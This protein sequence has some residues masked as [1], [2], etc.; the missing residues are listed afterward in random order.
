ML[1][2]TVLFTV[3]AS[4][5][6]AIA[7]LPWLFWQE[8]FFGSERAF[9]PHSQSAQAPR[10]EL[11]VPPERTPPRRPRAARGRA[12]PGRERE[13]VGPANQPVSEAA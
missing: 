4:Q 8:V 12:M 13:G 1:T 10:D 11:L 2:E 3:F 6:G 7:A 5:A 9:A